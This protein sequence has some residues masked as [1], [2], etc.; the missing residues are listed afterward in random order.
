MPK[1]QSLKLFTT[2]EHLCSYIEGAFATTLFVDP[3]THID[4]HTYSQ[5]AMLGFRRSGA[6]Y[7]KPHCARCNACI[8]V[9]IPVATFAPN[10]S[11][12][13]A[14]QK[15]SRLTTHIKPVGFDK[16]HYQL[17]EKYI[18]CQHGDGDMY[19]ATPDQYE[20]FIIQC[21]ENTFFVEFHQSDRLVAVA[22]VDELTNALSAVYT[23]YDPDCR[24]LN[25]G[26]LAVLWQVAHAKRMG[27]DFVYLGYWI[28]ACAKMRYKSRFRPLEQLAEEGWQLV[29]VADHFGNK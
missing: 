19:P 23:F 29:T 15:A 28:A 13:R 18:N 24:H 25:L 7:Y 3:S 4:Q 21:S 1:L 27:L 12:T 11:Q 9:R 5:L 17:Y 8:P 20:S 2:P 16:K 6:N 26:T 14:L 10:R 22:V